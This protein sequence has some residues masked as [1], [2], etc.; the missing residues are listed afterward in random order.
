[1]KHTGGITRYLETGDE[2]IRYKGDGKT[3]GLDFFVKKECKNQTLWISYTL[4]KTE[5]HF[6]Y[7][8]T[9]EYISA[10]GTA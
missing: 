3:K 5:E 4:S 1:M 2:I 7:F 10:I 8:K 6:P 9:A